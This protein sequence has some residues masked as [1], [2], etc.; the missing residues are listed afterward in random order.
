VISPDSSIATPVPR[1]KIQLAVG[2]GHH[3]FAPHDLPL[4]VGVG[5]VFAGAVVLV[6]RCRRVPGQ[7]FQPGLVVGVQTRFV[8]VDDDRRRDVHRVGQQQTS[9]T[10]AARTASSHGGVMLIN[11]TRPGTVKVKCCV[12]DFMTAYAARPEPRPSSRYRI[13]PS[14]GRIST[15]STHSSLAAMSALL[16]TIRYST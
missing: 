11:P 7:A 12:C 8:V 5:V 13:A 4:Q 2:D 16:V 15:T 9:R 10:P 14:T 1:P 3:H 6:L